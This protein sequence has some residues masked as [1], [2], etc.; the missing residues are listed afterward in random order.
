MVVGEQKRAQSITQETEIE[1]HLNKLYSASLHLNDQLSFNLLHND[2]GCFQLF[3]P[4]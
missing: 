1:T 2:S 3:K 4:N